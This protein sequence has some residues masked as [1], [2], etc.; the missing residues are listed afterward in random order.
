MNNLDFRRLEIEMEKTFNHKMTP[1]IIKAGQIKT[2]LTIDRNII[3]FC[4]AI[5]SNKPEFVEVYP[6]GERGNCHLNVALAANR[7]G[8][9]MVSGYLIWTIA[10]HVVSAEYHSVW[11]RPNGILLDVTPPEDDCKTVVFLPCGS[12]DPTLPDSKFWVEHNRECKICRFQRQ[13][14]YWRNENVMKP[15][16]QDIFD[17]WKAIGIKN[18]DLILDPIKSLVK[19]F[20]NR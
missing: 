17:E 8:G 20:E 15:V 6:A 19:Y 14:E 13:R 9:E 10:N 5:T 3:S 18:E 16:R 11:R 2:P 4:K 12:F 7:D 1:D